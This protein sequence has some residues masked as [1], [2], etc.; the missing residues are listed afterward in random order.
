MELTIKNTIVSFFVFFW[1]GDKTHRRDEKP[2]LLKY[3]TDYTVLRSNK[4]VDGCCSSNHYI[5]INSAARTPS[6]LLPI[7]VSSATRYNYSIGSFQVMIHWAFCS[8]RKSK[9]AFIFVIVAILLALGSAVVSVTLQGEDG[10]REEGGSSWNEGVAMDVL[11]QW[12][13]GTDMQGSAW[14]TVKV[15]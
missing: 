11:W 10:K 6:T 9:L 7:S 12:R 14:G 13:T 3:S 1:V 2:I 15:L 8:D 5:Y 4:S